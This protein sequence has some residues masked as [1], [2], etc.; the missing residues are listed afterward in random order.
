MTKNETIEDIIAEMCGGPIP[1]HRHDRVLL[2]HFA[3]RIKAAHRREKAAHRREKA[4]IEAD[5]LAVGGFVE[6][7]RNRELSK[8]T[9]KN[10]ADFGQLGDAAKLRKA[11]CDMVSAAFAAILRYGNGEE[12]MRRLALCTD[13][14]RDAL[15]SPPRNCDVGTADEQFKRYLVFC[16]RESCAH[17]CQH[18][19][20]NK[21][22]LRGTSNS[23]HAWAQ[24]P[25][26]KGAK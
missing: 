22:R 6:A 15:A 9:S 25:Y 23:D 14:A 4:A 2:R 19:P 8:N 16:H 5:A 20:A 13:N 10:G 24:M 21:T 18:C 1:Q 26:E 3:A 11:L 12:E 7:S 17:G